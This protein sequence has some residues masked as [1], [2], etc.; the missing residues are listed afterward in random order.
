LGVVAELKKYFLIEKV[1]YLIAP[2]ALSGLLSTATG[3]INTR[4]RVG[5]FCSH[6]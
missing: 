3:L 6:P 5:S 1:E 2:T 4:R